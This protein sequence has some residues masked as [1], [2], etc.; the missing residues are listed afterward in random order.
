MG[1]S[2]LKAKRMLETWPSHGKYIHTFI[3]YK[4]FHTVVSTTITPIVLEAMKTAGIASL[5]Q[6]QRCDASSKGMSST[7]VDFFHRVMYSRMHGARHAQVVRSLDDMAEREMAKR[8]QQNK[9]STSQK[10]FEELV[11][12][13]PDPAREQDGLLADGTLS[14][15]LWVTMEKHCQR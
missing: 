14:C 5:L 6:L 15:D 13:I 3:Y 2:R 11:K 12:A 10:E 8:K 4:L 9:Y 1:G 7:T